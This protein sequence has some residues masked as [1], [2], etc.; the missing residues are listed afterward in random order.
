[1]FFLCK[2]KAVWTAAV[3]P[4]CRV[5]CSSTAAGCTLNPDYTS[6]THENNV[7][8]AQKEKSPLSG[9]FSLRKKKEKKNPKC[10]QGFLQ[11][12]N[13]QRSWGESL[14]N[15]SQEHG[16]RW[17]NNETPPQEPPQ[18]CSPPGHITGRLG[19]GYVEGFF[20]FFIF[21]LRRGNA[22]LF[23]D[24][25]PPTPQK[26]VRSLLGGGAREGGREAGWVGWIR[27]WGSDFSP[28]S[29]N[30]QPE[31]SSSRN[32]GWNWTFNPSLS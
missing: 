19:L 13:S 3:D 16:G 28:A 10:C 31:R 32:Q 9:C 2:W 15:R 1:M 8:K 27:R 21:G 5:S 7:S 30:L 24:P 6:E 20:S 26:W 22:A 23:Y 14:R 11:T 4:L 29:G 17:G 18:S 12:E 25:H